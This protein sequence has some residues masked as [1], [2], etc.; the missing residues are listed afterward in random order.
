MIMHSKHSINWHK[1]ETVL[2]DMDGTLLDLHFDT[3]FWLTVIPEYISRV[4]NRPR[5][6]VV[7]DIMQRYQQVAGSLEWYCIEYWQVELGIDIMQLKALYTHKIQWLKDVKPFLSALKNSNIQR[8]LVTNAHPLSLE[9]KILH[10]QLDKHLDKIF[11]TH[12]FGSP[13][14]SAILWKKLQKEQ[15]YNP[16]T[17][18]FID[19][20][21][22]LLEASKQAGITWQLGIF[23]PNSQL[24]GKEME[25][26]QTIKNYR[27]LTQ[28]LLINNLS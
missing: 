7:S 23:Q 26:F 18:L 1:I 4:Q 22:A 8:V 11:T 12:Q 20:N 10:T 9:L 27:E 24:P 25:K 19:D 21:E 2:L 28:E 3:Y 6:E 16:Q 17:T 15:D 5:Q 14:E 13:K